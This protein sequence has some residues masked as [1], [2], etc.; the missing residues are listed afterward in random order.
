MA[1]HFPVDFC[2]NALVSVQR[3]M[4]VL[5]QDPPGLL[6]FTRTLPPPPS[7]PRRKKSAMRQ[8]GKRRLLALVGLPLLSLAWQRPAEATNHLLF[9]S[10]AAANV[11]GN[12]Q[13]GFFEIQTSPDQ[14]LW[15]PG[16]FNGSSGQIE[17]ASAML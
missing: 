10:E 11:D 3:G 16:H 14:T 15:G 8:L 9:A 6:S 7:R 1:K 2:I 13:A 5:T 12:A 4:T 17:R